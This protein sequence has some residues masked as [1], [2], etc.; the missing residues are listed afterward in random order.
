[1]KPVHYLSISSLSWAPEGF[2]FREREIKKCTIGI[3]RYETC[4][5]RNYFGQGSAIVTM[6]NEVL[7]WVLLSLSERLLLSRKWLETGGQ[8]ILERW[9]KKKWIKTSKR[10]SFIYAYAN[11]HVK[12]LYQ[13]LIFYRISIKFRKQLVDRSNGFQKQNWWEWFEKFWAS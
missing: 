13:C 7:L 6:M 4:A 1:M 5:L 10:W 2:D 3:V 11:W 8:D 9:N 12:L